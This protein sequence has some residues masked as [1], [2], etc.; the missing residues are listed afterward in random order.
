MRKEAEIKVVCTERNGFHQESQTGIFTSTQV[1]WPRDYKFGGLTKVQKLPVIHVSPDQACQEVLGFGGAFTEASCYLLDGLDMNE[2][3]IVMKRL[4]S[5]SGGMGFNVGRLTVGQCD[6]GRYPYSYDDVPDDVAM[7]HFSIK[8]D[9]ECMIPIIREA[10][11]VNPDMFLLSSPWSPPGWMKTGGLMTGGWM[12]EKY[13]GAYADY[14]LHYL[15]A[16]RAEGIRIHAL[17]TQNESETDQLSL[18]PACYWHPEME[19][20]FL[21]DELLPRLKRN[22]LD[23]TEFWIMDHNYLMWR[24]AKWMLDEPSLKAVVK[25]IAYHPYE[26]PA[27]SMSMLHEL[28]PDVDAHMTEQGSGFLPTPEAV[29]ENGAM[30]V[31]MMRNWSRSIF[32]WNIALDETGKPHIGPFFQHGSKDGGGLLQI[33]SGTNNVTYGCQ[34]WALGHFSKYVKRG[35]VRLASTCDMQGI[36][37]VAFRNPDGGYAVVLVNR[38]PAT[39]ATLVVGERHAQVPVPE[40]AMM[41]LLFR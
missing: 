3:A 37:Q 12:R 32:C 22:G 23:D 28:H 29:C 25:G 27:E 40:S 34:F 19:M 9:Q 20:A 41:T 6:F 7:E 5:E 33:H 24:R 2:R 17:T 13:L 21:R 30:Y 14:Y 10:L 26:G 31:D 18:M 11:A 8:P 1:T 35:A 16:Y 15:L 4:F 39:E 38:G 36:C